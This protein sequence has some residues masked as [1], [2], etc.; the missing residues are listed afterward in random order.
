[1]A[2]LRFMCPVYGLVC[3]CGNPGALPKCFLAYLFYSPLNNTV[4]EPLGLFNTSWSNVM[5]YPPAFSIRA[6]AVSVNLSAQT[7]SLP[8]SSIL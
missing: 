8:I 5:H 2:R 3:E 6:L 7:L 1:M 4:L